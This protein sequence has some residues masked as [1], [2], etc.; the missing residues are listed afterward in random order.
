MSQQGRLRDIESAFETLTG[1]TGGAVQPDGSGNV[2]LLGSSPISVTGNPGTYTLTIDTDG[3]LAITYTA[4]SGSATPSGDNLNVLGESVQGIETSGSGATLTISG[5]DATTSQKGVLETS[6]DAESIAGSATDVS[7]TPSSL[8]AKLGTQTS[9]AIPYGNS[10]SGAFNW[11]AGATNGQ[12]LIGATSNPPQFASVTSIGST[13]EVTGGANSL[14]LDLTSNV[15]STAINGWNGSI[16]QTPSVSITSDGATIT[17][18]VEQDGGGDLTVVFSDGFYDWD[19]TP[20]DTVTLTAGTDTSPQTNYI[21]FLQSTKTLTASTSGF[22]SAEYAPIATAICQSASSLQTE[23]PY[24][25]QNWTDHV[26]DTDEQGHIEHLNFWIRQQAATWLSGVAQTYT[27]T[28]NVGTPDNVFI[29]TTAGVALQLHENTVDSFVNADDYYVINDFTTPY[30]IVNDLNALLTDSTGA[31]MSGKYFSLVL[32]ISVNSNGETKRFI[33][34]PS[35]SYS[36]STDLDEDPSNY[37]NFTIPSGFKSTGILV[38]QWKLRHQNASGGTWTSIEEVDLRGQIPSLAA[39][40]ENV[41]PTTFDD[42]SFRI[43]DNSDNTKQIAFEASSITTATTRTI[44]MVDG[45]INLAEVATTFTTD[46]GNAT[47][48]SNS[49]SVVGNGVVST[50]ASG[51]T[52]TISSSG[53]ISWSVE[54]GTTA[55]LSNNTGNIG[56]NASG[57]TFTLPATSSVGDIIRITG[58]QASWTI[59]QNAGQTIYV[60]NQSTTTGAGGSLSSTNTRDAVEIV[61]VV[62]DTD[63][64]VLSSMGNLTVT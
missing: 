19:T 31:S 6:T 57:V 62:T 42:S 10:T 47:P 52:I 38:S 32:W 20:A 59:A 28:P 17:C 7:V 26:V 11:T 22:P 48:S 15:Q 21:Y 37:T 44:T 55:N 18:S 45:D 61:C 24:K 29:S 25:Q 2:N 40:G 53:E 3:T 43:Y 54:T 46:S 33:N 64:Q 30:T 51:S 58:L 41:S 49:I 34:L 1:N 60:G 23:G 13:I 8:A 50:S 14:N 39:G 16:L 12:L 56:N 4:D 27:I 36:N 63:Y 35:G 9:N 5:I